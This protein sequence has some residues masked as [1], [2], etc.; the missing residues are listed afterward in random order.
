MS[1]AKNYIYNVVYQLLIL[2]LPLITVP[3]VSRILGSNG[4]GINAY[5]NSIVQ[6]FVLAGTIGISLYG[7]R[8]IAYVRDKKDELSKTFW[9]IF[10]LKLI[11]TALA[12]IAFL[13]FIFIIKSKYTSIYFIQSLAILSATLDISWF[14]MGIEDFKKTV[15]RNFIVKMIGVVCI[16]I[17]VKNKSDL[18]KYVLILCISDLIGQGIMWM[19]MKSYIN[20][21]QLTFND[22]NKH[23][24]PAVQLFIPQ[25]AIQIYVVLDKTMVGM[26]STPSEVG[27]Y[28]NSQKI[29]KMTL[30]VVTSMGTVML[31]RVTN[32]FAKGDLKKVKE[33]LVKSF[34]FSSYLA[35]PMMFG[36]IGIANEFVPWFFGNDFLK[37][38][39]LIIIIS[40]IIVAIAWSN[41]LGMQIMLPVGKVKEFTISVTVGAVVNFIINLFLIKKYASLGASVASVIAEFAVTLVQFYLMREYI[42]I[43]SMFNNIW[44][45]FLAS[46]IMLLFLRIIGNY[47]KTSIK[48]TVVQ[49]VVGML[50]YFVLL[51]M[52]KSNVNNYIINIVKRKFLKKT[53]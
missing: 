11:T 20:K 52:L 35:I 12:Y 50:T 9:G 6:Y 42:A 41:V 39:S 18:N 24:I 8:T 28:D 7:N 3:Y 27:F 46:G 10:I 31:P 21:I 5:T 13:V 30:A 33:Y 1:I 51:V 25:I 16:F 43:K 47:M 49:V 2:I 19:Y 53:I 14:F 4:V 48:T 38:S 36:M 15:T 17:F 29:V 37:C 45:Y 40:P 34:E 32:T 22:I 23:F 44:K 26:F